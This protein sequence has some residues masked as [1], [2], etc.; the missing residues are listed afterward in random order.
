MANTSIFNAFERMWQ[1]VVTYTNTE[2]SKLI[3]SAPTTLD[4]LGEI[5]T[6]MEEN[7]DVVQALDNAIGQKS[8]VQIITW[9]EN[10]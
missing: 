2:I 9:G 4:T 1:H 3:N 5:A 6:A 10:D 7:A 8:Q